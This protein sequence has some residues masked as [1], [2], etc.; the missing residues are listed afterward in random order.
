M[1]TVTGVR[2]TR[3]LRGRESLIA[4][5]QEQGKTTDEAL[6]STDAAVTQ[7]QV[8]ALE[9][10]QASSEDELRAELRLLRDFE[11]SVEAG[12]QMATFQGPLCGEPV[13]GMGWVVEK[14]EISH[15]NDDGKLFSTDLGRKLTLIGKGRAAVVGTLISS[16]RDSCRAGMLDWSPRIK[17]AMY[18]CDIQASSESTPEKLVGADQ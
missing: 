16:V 17:L 2:L 8:A 14:I 18:T 7:D 3:R 12:F 4:E 5:A 15:D 11:N 6:A 9:S 1:S 13:V 10:T